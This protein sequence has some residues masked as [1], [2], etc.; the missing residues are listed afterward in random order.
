[1]SPMLLHCTNDRVHVFLFHTRIKLVDIN[2][3]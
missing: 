1:M 2:R 3:R